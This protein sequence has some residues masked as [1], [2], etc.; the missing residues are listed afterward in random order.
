MSNRRFSPKA[1]AISLLVLLALGV[2][3]AGV[4]VYPPVL[5]YGMIG[6]AG[7]VAY[8]AVYFIV[9]GALHRHEAVRSSRSSPEA[10]GQVAENEA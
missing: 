4:W 7:L 3:G 1:A 6:L 9:L 8:A 5:L 10:T 2:I